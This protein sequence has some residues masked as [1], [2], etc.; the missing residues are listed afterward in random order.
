MRVIITDLLAG[1]CELTSKES[2]ECLRLQLDDESPSF[3]C[4]PTELIKLLRL[5]KKQTGGSTSPEQ[6]GM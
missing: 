1:T 5:Q 6:K 4:V 2:P 3:V